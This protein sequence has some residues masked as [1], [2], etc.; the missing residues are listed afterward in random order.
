LE[1]G[2]KTKAKKLSEMKEYPTTTFLDM[3]KLWKQQRDLLSFD[4]NIDNSKIKDQIIKFIKY[5]S[6]NEDNIKAIRKNEMYQ[7]KF[8][9][10]I[11]II[12]F[13][14]KGKNIEFST[15]LGTFHSAK[16]LEADN[17]FV[18][19]GTCNYFQNINDSEKRCFYVASSRAKE[20][21]FFIGTMNGQKTFL[22]EEFRDIIK[23]Y[24]T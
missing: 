5:F 18:F 23:Q 15:L 4:E 22:E 8:R 6:F 21:I 24:R 7:N 20:R 9:K 3:T 2:V 16:G 19:L 13:K 1:Y 11:S 17:I 12:D 10:I 14:E